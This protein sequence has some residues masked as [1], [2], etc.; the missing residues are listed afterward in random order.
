MFPPNVFDLL[1]SRSH[2]ETMYFD[3]HNQ[4]FSWSLKQSLQVG[5]QVFKEAFKGFLRTAL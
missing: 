5:I 4:H 2:I 1:A 3:V